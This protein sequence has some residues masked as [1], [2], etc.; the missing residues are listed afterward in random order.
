MNNIII[1]AGGSGSRMGAAIPKQFIAIGDKPIL[2]HTIDCFTKFDIEIN[3]IVVLP[4]NQIDNW[5]Q[6]CDKHKFATKHTIVAGGNTRFQSV[7]NGLSAIDN[8]GLVGVHDG[9]RPFVSQSTLNNCYA[10]AQQFENAIPVCDSVESVRV[11]DAKGNHAIDRST[12][13]L[14]QTP[15]VFSSQM[16]KEAYSLDYRASFTDDA[17]VVEAAGFEIHLTQGNRENIKI[18][19]P[20]DLIFAETLVLANH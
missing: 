15:Q 12:I 2:M 18:T 11:V 10:D 3:I 5:K 20:S 14:V 9:V 4:D 8:S 19:T 6:L 1:V 16:I 7:K 17:S 13:K